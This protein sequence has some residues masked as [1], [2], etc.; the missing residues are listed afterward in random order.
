MAG[1]EFQYKATL[2]IQDILSGVVKVDKATEDL[3]R[4][5]DTNFKKAGKTVDGLFIDKS[6]RIREANGRFSQMGEAARKG[7]EEAEKGA[8]LSGVKIGAMAGAVS[9]LVTEFINLGQQAVGVLID[10]GKQSVQTALEV[11][12]LKAR[13]GGIFRGDKEAADE[14]F[15]F[16][17]KKSKELGIDLSE[18]A[19]AFIP[20]TE[21][22]QQFE[23]VAKIATA[24]ARSDPEQGA[25]G[26]RIA[27]IEALSGTFTSLQRRFE[28]PK[29]DI[30][31][32]K[33]AFDTGGM[34]AFLSEF[35]KVLAAS[36][37]SFDDLANTA[38][39]SFDR[40]AIAGEQ[41]G[42][43]LGAPILEA[44][45]AAADKLG[46]FVS[47]NEDDLIVFADTI[48]R[49]VAEVINLISSVDL[50]GLD[51]QSLIDFA[52]YVQRIVASV[53]LLA[54]QFSGLS[55]SFGAFNTTITGG[56]DVFGALSEALL[57]IDDAFVT[58]SQGIALAKA[59]YAGLTAS[60]EPLID[61]F[62]QLTIAAAQSAS[63][64]YTGAVESLGAAAGAIQNNTASQAA[65]NA[66]LMES[67]AS[68]ANYQKSIDNNADSQR[69]LREELEKQKTAGTGAADAVQAKGAA[70]RQAAEEADKLT[71]AQTKVNEKL[72]DAQQDFQRKLEDID[73]T[74][75]RKRLD[76]AIDF[77]QKREDAA[78]KNLQKLDDIQK[79]Y[80]QDVDD[81][82]I[83]LGRK[84]EDIARKFGQ[85]RIDLERDQRKKRV[86]IEK[87]YRLK[88]QE[89]QRQFL[90]DA[91]EA[92]RNRDAV[93]FLRAMKERDKQVQDAQLNRQQEIQETKTTGEQRKQ[94][95]ELQRQREIEDARIANERKLEDLKLNLE[96]QI[97]AQNTAYARE[98]DDLRTNEQRKYE[99]LAM[100]RQR[101]IED[102]QKAYDRK[103]EDLRASLAAELAVIEEFAAKK[104]ALLAQGAAMSTSTR[105]PGTRGSA[106]GRA[107]SAGTN[108]GSIARQTAVMQEFAEGG[109]VGAGRPVIV[110]ERGPEIFTPNTAGRIIPNNQL[111]MPAM[112]AGGASYSVTNNN[113]KSASLGGLLDA[114]SLDALLQARVQNILLS[115][116]GNL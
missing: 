1:E 58:L 63:F 79:K 16:I 2:N 19:G 14:A 30:D 33:E 115:I 46:E 57:N 100:A 42:G 52:D 76:I 109:I 45:Q 8:Q 114:G 67:Q 24:L 40:L 26:A 56:V 5:I 104:A 41:L 62:K 32:L 61:V 9:S 105:K 44:L 70:D 99:E 51:I 13:L 34:E 83:E 97:E 73:I 59:S 21:N 43:R 92:E 101:D 17:Q 48:G 4:K 49:T 69:N 80:G 84:E 91:E 20:K 98:L 28:I 110:G 27:L 39:A 88:I 35:E 12:T 3:A 36:G 93:A 75:E 11:D 90:T 23:Q 31:R 74:T 65:F 113:Q 6:G 78:K 95:L 77:A 64:N 87:D 82:A 18:L 107:P 86:E 71:E 96:R 10:I 38:Q 108:R 37:K 15:T 85:E 47:M 106:G 25:I 53:Q 103:L 22:L 89:I 29:Q 112:S 50:S 7:F 111:L 116:L 72:A 60:I 94:E 66:S 81:A 102:A 68:F 55:V 54:S